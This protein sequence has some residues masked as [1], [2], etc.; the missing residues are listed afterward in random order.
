MMGSMGLFMLLGLVLLTALIGATVY[1]AARAASAP[2][3]K[4]PDARAVLRERLADGSIS[5]EEYYERDSA[6]R[7]S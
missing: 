4:G 7:E 3:M 6:L 2:L 5:A 1:I